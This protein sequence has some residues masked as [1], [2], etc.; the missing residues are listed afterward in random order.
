MCVLNNASAE[1]QTIHV[2]VDHAPPY[3]KVGSDGDS[4]GLILDI[5]RAAV[6][7]KYH[8][9]PVPCPLSRCLRMLEQG[10]VDIMGGLL[11]TPQR[12]AN[13]VFIEPPYMALS[14]SFVFYTKKGSNITVNQFEDLYNKRIA[15]MRGAAF[16]ER[17]DKDSKLSKIE[18]TS[19]QVAFDL[20]LKERVDL[21]I[22]V[23][24]TAEVAMKVLKQPIS[25]LEKMNYR[26]TNVIYG[27]MVT[28]KEF[29]QTNAAQYLRRA[30]MDMAKSKQLDKIIAPYALPPIPESLLQ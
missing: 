9:R 7:D 28:S 21:A 25:Q 4:S 29:A 15:V 20:V 23:E 19:E 1:H 26:Y 17:F 11:K 10:D 12:E 22:A 24:D 14:S 30:V 18:V 5:T 27:Y 3:S 13:M 16:F 2:A 6:A 8:I